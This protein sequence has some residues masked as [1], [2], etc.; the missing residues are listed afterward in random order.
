MN[1]LL[2]YRSWDLSGREEAARQMYTWGSVV[3]LPETNSVSVG[4]RA[5]SSASLVK[6]GPW[7][8]PGE[9]A[10][11]PKIGRRKFA[12]SSITSQWIIRFRSDF[13]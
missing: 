4:D 7:E 9:S 1:F 10:T 3:L 12:K 11:T 8:P 6:F 5:M 13:V 2:F